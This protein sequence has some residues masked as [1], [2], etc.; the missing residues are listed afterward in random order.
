MPFNEKLKSLLFESNQTA[1][2][3]CEDFLQSAILNDLG[4]QSSLQ[5]Y[6]QGLYNR[7]DLKVGTFKEKLSQSGISIKTRSELGELFV[8]GLVGMR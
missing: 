1:D 2:A 3:Y 5:E 6:Y 8:Y 4:V 7:D